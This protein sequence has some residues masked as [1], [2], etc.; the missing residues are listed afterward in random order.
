MRFINK[1]LVK[2]F[3]NG[4]SKICITSNFLRGVFS[5]FSNLEYLDPFIHSLELSFKNILQFFLV[6]NLILFL[7]LPECFLVLI[8]RRHLPFYLTAARKLIR[9]YSNFQK[10]TLLILTYKST[11]F[12]TQ[13][14]P[15]QQRLQESLVDFL[16]RVRA[17]KV[18]HLKWVS[19]RDRII[20]QMIIGYC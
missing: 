4:S 5:N 16:K 18:N 17:L 7:L 1:I 14:H 20:R 12:L 13:R 11:G 9:L 6:H 10:M 19:S 2:V 8:N 3:K 15:I